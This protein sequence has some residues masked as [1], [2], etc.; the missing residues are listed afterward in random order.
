MHRRKFLQLSALS[1]LSMPFFQCESN[2]NTQSSKYKITIHSDQSVGHL[3]WQGDS[4]PVDNKIEKTEFLV[5]GGGIAGLTAC[6][7]LKN[8]DFLLVE[9]D[10][11]LG[12]TASAFNYEKT[13]FGQGAHYDLAYPTYFGEEVLQFWEDMKIISFDK[14]TSYW[15]F[16]DKKYMISAEKEGYCFD[17]GIFRDD[18]LPDVPETKKLVKLFEGFDKKM[19]LPTRLIDK[20]FHYLNELSFENYLKKNIELNETLRQAFDYQMLDDFGGTSDEVSALAGVYYYASRPY[21]DETKMI[22]SP[23]E[24]NFYFIQ[25]MASQIPKE[26]ILTS[27]LV[28]KIKEQKDGFEVEIIDVKNKKI[29]IVQTKKIVYAAPKHTLKYIFPN[30]Y[31]LFNQQLQ[32]PWLVLN[33]VLKDNFITAK[34]Y[35]QNEMITDDLRKPVRFLGFVDSETQGGEEN[36]KRVLSAYYT[37]KPDYRAVLGN[38]KEF[39]YQKLAEETIEKIAKY[40]HLTKPLFTPYIEA[41]FGKIMGHAMPVPNLNY[42]FKNPN[43]QRKNKNIV[44]AGVDV[45]RLPLMLEATDSGLEAIKMLNMQV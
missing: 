45:A 44:Y 40:F 20:E 25:K 7:K 4:F 2:H 13:V 36:T 41:I 19:K 27:H 14:L 8:K 43:E 30:D 39:D 37:F 29:K 31:P 5:V 22:F 17:K 26:K 16:N 33:F 18:V 21:Y 28:K 24:G 12:G 32:S 35:W 1:A 3:I 11:Q 6:S 23:P 42:L 9:I 34:N 38:P 10:E 15:Q